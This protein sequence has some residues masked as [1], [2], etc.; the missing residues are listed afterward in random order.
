MVCSLFVWIQRGYPECDIEVLCLNGT[1]KPGITIL[2]KDDK[3]VLGEMSNVDR[4]V[5]F[6]Q[7]NDIKLYL[8]LNR[9]KFATGIIPRRFLFKQAHIGTV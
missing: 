1:V 7:P 6:A 8:L 9:M 5:V 4:L 2:L 3:L